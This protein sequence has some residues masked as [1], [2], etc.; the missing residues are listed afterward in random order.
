VAVE[1]A[2]V[3]VLWSD[4][5]IAVVDKPSGLLVH[6]TEEA[7]D[8][9]VLLQRV[10]R[11]F[12]AHVHAVQRLDRPA[13]GVILFALHPEAARWAQAAMADP[14]ARKEYRVLV[15]GQPEADEWEVDRPLTDEHGVKRDARSAF[16]V[17][18]RLD[19][20][21]LL[22]ARTFSGRRHQ[23]RRHLSHCAH[24]ILGDTTHGKG[25]LN[26]LFRERYGLDRLFLHAAA[27]EL[28][29]GVTGERLRV[30]APLPAELER[31]LALL[32]DAMP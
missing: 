31:T 24:Q 1:R 28:V 30:E 9:D 3:E 8:R 7:P 23:L 16:R 12:G 29:H 5:H 25:R 4:E 15:R 10:A 27:L 26:Q 13:S 21:A 6:R 14:E 18:E 20:C 11:H 19:R 17:V 2:G 22:W 32:R